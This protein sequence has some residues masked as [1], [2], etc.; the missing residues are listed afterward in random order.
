MARILKSPARAFIAIFV[1]AFAIRG[2]VLVSGLLPRDYFRPSGEIGKV[3]VSLARSGEFADPYLI[4]TGSTA[5]PTPVYA[6]LLGLIYTLFGVTLTAA[7]VRALI[8]I[9]AFSA[10][11]AMLPWL[12]S[13]LGLGAGA[14]VLG[15]FAGAL[16]PQQGIAEVIGGSDQPLPGIVLG[17]L[18]VAFLHRWTTRQPLAGSSFLLGIGCGAAVHLSP[19]LLCVV[20]GWM[21]FELA[22][23]RRPRTVACVALGAIL[24]CVPW[25]WRNYAAFHEFLFIRGNFGLEL[26]IANH[27]G[28]DPDIDVMVAREKPF[29]HPSASLEEATLVR[30]LGE[31]EYMR[32]ARQEAL[33]WIWSHPGECL[34]LTFLRA[35][36]FWFGPWSQPWSVLAILPVSIL[37][38]LGLRCRV[39]LLTPPQRAALLMPL[40]AFPLIYYFVSYVAH[41]R[42]PLE[43]L[44]LLLAG[45]GVLSWKGWKLA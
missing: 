32:R 22:W 24:A 37:A 4:P 18:A 16:M 40:A 15:G 41:Y 10:L 11:Y 34:R 31:A 13:R 20:L 38:L 23:Q 2:G 6:G 8:A 43:G 35:L 45:A 28:A 27:P 5:H 17:M 44:L 42:A 19:A 14:G 26:R 36:Y 29:R 3:A 25:A 9:T 21:G 1:L 30:D 39:P 12:S 33:Q 7:Y